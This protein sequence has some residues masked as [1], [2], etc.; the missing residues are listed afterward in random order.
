[1]VEPIK[2]RIS[3]GKATGGKDKLLLVAMHLFAERGFD[4]VTVRDISSA[5]GVS[6]G[7]INHHFRSKEGLRQAVDDYFISRT[8]AAIDRAFEAS[9]NLDPDA[10]GEFQRNWIIK[11]QDEWPEFVAYLRRA[12]IEASPWG[13]ALFRRYHESINR[14]IQRFDAAGKVS[15]E[16]D[17]FW[18]PLLYLFVL[19]GPLVLDPFIKS[20]FGRSAYEPEMWARFQKAFSAMMW[21]GISSRKP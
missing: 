10:M 12:I 5:A 14:M 13:E 2:L 4:G 18:L 17:R 9:N 15:P 6:V 1:M 20:T 3:E 8:G 19:F 11:Y 7:L 16:T 21:N